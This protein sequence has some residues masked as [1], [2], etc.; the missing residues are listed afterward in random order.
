[1]F[2]KL[3]KNIIKTFSNGKKDYYK[4]LGVNKSSTQ[5]EVKKAFAAKARKYHPDTNKGKDTKDK[6][7]E[8]TEAYQTLNDKNK[9]KVYD[10]YGMGAD[11]QKQYENTGQGFGRQQGFGDFDFGGF[12]DFFGAK[13]NQQG[14]GGFENIFEDFF[15]FEGEGNN[16][17]QNKRPKRGADIVINLQINFLDSV[18]GINKEINFKVKDTCGTCKGTKCRP[19]SKPSKCTTCHGRG[20]INYQQGPMHIQMACNVC[21]GI[22]TIISSPCGTCKGHGTAYKT[23][24]EKISIPKGIATGQNLRVGGKGNKGDNNGQ[25]GDLIIKIKVKPDPFYKREGYDVYTELPITIVQ[26]VLGMKLNINTLNGKREINIPPGTNHGSKIK[27]PGEGITKLAPNQNQKG[28]HYCVFSIT[29][30]KTLSSTTRKLYEQI[31]NY[32]ETGE[33]EGNDNS[34]KADSSKDKKKD[35]KGIFGKV[36]NFVKNKAN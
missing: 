17:R 4:I 13:Q 6:F 32:E 9:R 21:H 34:K 12:G 20:N 11:E 7:S 8:I 36:K 2:R 26:A 16:K 24:K 33:I 19:G 5:A 22:G 29:V 10:Q 25:N 30:P 35:D 18:K 14:P 31:R 28:D 3:T 23:S 27:L 15:S 1:M